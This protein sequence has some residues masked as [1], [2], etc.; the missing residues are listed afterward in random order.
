[1]EI[2]KTEGTPFRQL[3]Q[4]RL[5]GVVQAPSNV[6]LGGRGD[7]CKRYRKGGGNENS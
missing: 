2:A 3:R 5:A 7:T 6:W 1:M 4:R